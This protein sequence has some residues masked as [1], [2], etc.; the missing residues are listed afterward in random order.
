M[1]K[2]NGIEIRKTTESKMIL[3]DLEEY[4]HL[5]DIETRF[6]IIKNQMIH[7]DYGPIH[8]QVILG[9]ENECAAKD[10]ELKL[11]MLPLLGKKKH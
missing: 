8:Q 3:V 4:I 7:A 2:N 5:K 11:D 10:K 6:T 1:S 9:I